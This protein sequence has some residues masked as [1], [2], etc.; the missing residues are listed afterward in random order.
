MKKTLS[1]LGLLL[2][3]LSS[4]PTVFAA[5]NPATIPVPQ[6]GMESR[7]VEK[8][9]AVR[10]H[11]YDLLMI[12]DSITHQFDDAEFQSVWRQFYAPRNALDLG[13]GGAR[14]ENILWN[15]ANG[16]LTNQS[17]KVVTLLIG[18][19][20]ADDVN[21]P[22]V[23]PAEEIAEGTAAIVKLL[24]E[25]LPE[26]KILLLRTFPRQNLYSNPDGSERGSVRQRADTVL[27]AGELTKRLADDK[28]VFYLDLNSVFLLPDGALD[29]TLMPDLLHPSPAGA[30]AWAR[31]ME[32]ML[33][34][35]FGDKS[36]DEMP[37]SR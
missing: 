28:H 16:Q 25:K 9:A 15:L 2:A 20:N 27:K 8:V 24:R 14:T 4:V 26:T 3:I 17:P 6:R 32:P 35:L 13:F 34:K 7:H 29:P 18:T 36:R 10:A 30:L 33:S 1:M 23:Y 22:S 21:Y 19:N 12:G 31:A 5:P 11:R 37:A